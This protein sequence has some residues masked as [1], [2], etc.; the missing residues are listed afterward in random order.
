[1]AD[2]SKNQKIQVMVV[3][4]HFVVRMGLIKSINLEAD[5]TVHCEAS[6]GEQAIDLYRQYRSDIVLMDLKLPGISGAQATKAIRKEFPSTAV[7]IYSMYDGEED[8]YRS[9]KAGAATY[10]LKTAGRDELIQTI[11]AVHADEYQIPPMV[12]AR[13]AERMQRSRPDLTARELDVLR[14]IVRGANTREIAK[15]LAITTVTVHGH[16]GRILAKLEAKDRTAAVVTAVQ[17]G[18]LRTTSARRRVANRFGLPA[19][20]TCEL[21][22]PDDQLFVGEVEVAQR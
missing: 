5:M 4:D 9:V 21:G 20:G 15:E 19:G 18:V 7:I 3:D 6:N 17:R 16:V 13:L 22:K 11:R 12:A 8:I 10:L 1:M 14:L 2:N